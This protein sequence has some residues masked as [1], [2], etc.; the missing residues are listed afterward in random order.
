MM[1]QLTPSRLRVILAV[2]IAL[3]LFLV[4]LVGAQRWRAVQ[5]QRM[6]TPAIGLGE[7][8]GMRDPEG[9]L[10]E[11]LAR[12]SPSD[13]AILQA[14]ARARLGEL[15]NARRDF[16]SAVE[17]A[18][19]EIGRDSIDLTAL[20]EAMAEARRQRQRFGPL[21]EGI[22][23][24]AVPRMTPEGRRALSRAPGVAAP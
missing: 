4:A 13:A 5:V 23:L 22:L 11:F 6:A 7:G 16:V 20:R 1:P 15:L 2:S 21:L 10:Q 17:R 24:D 19:A 8:R 14:V 12:L 3:N 9:T 18:R